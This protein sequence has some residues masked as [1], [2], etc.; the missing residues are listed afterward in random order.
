MQELFK[1][2]VE[3]EVQHSG[4]KKH[5]VTVINRSSLPYYFQIGKNKY[6]LNGMG[7]LYLQRPTKENEVKVT[8]LNMWCGHDEHPTVMVKLK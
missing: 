3:F 6:V 7:S 1:E 5:N 8:V 4:A 2:S